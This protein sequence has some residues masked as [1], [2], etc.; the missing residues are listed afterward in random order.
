[1]FPTSVCVQLLRWRP[2]LLL[3][4]NTELRRDGEKITK[5]CGLWNTRSFPSRAT[6]CSFPF[7]YLEGKM[8]FYHTTGIVRHLVLSGARD[9]TVK[10]WGHDYNEPF[11][12]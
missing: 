5:I 3:F 7:R 12:D 6:G 9:G 1:M 10:L 4:L 2:P 8:G 11:K